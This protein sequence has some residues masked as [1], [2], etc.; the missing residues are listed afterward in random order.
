MCLFLTVSWVGLR[1]LIVVFPGQTHFSHFKHNGFSQSY[2]LDQSIS[3]LRVVGLYLSFFIYF[4][5]HSVSKQWRPSGSALFA[6]VMTQTKKDAR[7]ICV[8]L[9]S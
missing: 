7:L 1:S 2:K 3:V 5:E 4:L 6:Y 8:N 9:A